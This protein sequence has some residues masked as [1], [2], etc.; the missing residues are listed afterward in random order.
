MKR[1]RRMTAGRGSVSRSER[2]TRSASASIISAFPSI[3]NLRARLIGTIVRGSN[4]A[5]SARQPTIKHSSSSPCLRRLNIQRVHSKYPQ[6]PH[7]AHGST[8]HAGPESSLS[9]FPC[10]LFESQ[11][12]LALA[13]LFQWESDQPSESV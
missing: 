11:V 12:R 1:V 13:C 9:R 10:T 2:T 7:S 8:T 6:L 4:D 5:F 3:T